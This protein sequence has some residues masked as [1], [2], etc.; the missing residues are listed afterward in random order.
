MNCRK[1]ALD[2]RY[3]LLLAISY[4]NK[5]LGNGAA[6]TVYELT[7]NAIKWGYSKPREAP[8]GSIL[9]RWIQQKEA[10]A[11]AT[12]AAARQLLGC[13]EY[14]PK[15]DGEVLALGL[16]LAEALPDQAPDQLQRLLPSALVAKLTR[17]ILEWA[18]S[19]R[20]Q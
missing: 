9:N 12:K 18:C 6:N 20:K 14:V 15:T 11:W 16:C 3:L 19:A 2:N 1:I 17:D 8:K 4:Q 7:Q 13:A 10:P 5:K